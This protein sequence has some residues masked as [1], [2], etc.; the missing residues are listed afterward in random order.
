[1]RDKIESTEKEL[2]YY[3]DLSGLENERDKLILTKAQK[4]KD[5][6][7]TEK[8]LLLSKL[9]KTK[10]ADHFK[11][12]NIRLVDEIEKIGSDLESAEKNSLEKY[13]KA[14][15]IAQYIKR[16][17]NPDQSRLVNSEQSAAD[18]EIVIRDLL[19]EKEGLE[20][21]IT[22]IE[23]DIEIAN[24]KI[25]QQEKAIELNV[26]EH[27]YTS[28]ELEQKRKQADYFFNNPWRRPK[29]TMSLKGVLDFIYN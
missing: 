7:K 22:S 4:I 13:K 16:V 28:S 1:M 23:S 3:S 5:L 21:E 24:A 15:Q 27:V 8:S 26:K 10:L 29:T 14:D 25:V 11:S 19:K 12:E 2:R 9:K 6:K 18:I 17:T 20:N